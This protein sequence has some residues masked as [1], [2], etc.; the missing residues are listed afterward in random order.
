[1]FVIIPFLF[2]F[3]YLCIGIVAGLNASNTDIST[4]NFPNLNV[5]FSCQSDKQSDKS[6]Q[7]VSMIVIE[8]A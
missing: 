4:I 8:E 3:V 1:M 5:S 6:Y 2:C 7:E